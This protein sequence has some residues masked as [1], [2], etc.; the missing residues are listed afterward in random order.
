M[1]PRSVAVAVALLLMG[2]L[3]VT[4]CAGPSGAPEATNSSSPEPSSAASGDL[5]R[6]TNDGRARQTTITGVVEES[7]VE[8]R[9]LVLRAS[10]KA[11][12]LLGLTATLV[13]GEQ[14]TVTG[15]LVPTLRSTCQVGVPFHVDRI[16]KVSHSSPGYVP[17]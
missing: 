3:A 8:G 5:T 17:R 4:S 6:P 2:S 13:A 10:G 14:A 15:R 1:P 11:Y 16:E 7:A 9:C 12:L